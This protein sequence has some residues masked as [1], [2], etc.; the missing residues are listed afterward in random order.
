MKKTLILA[1]ATLFSL[2]GVALAQETG[3]VRDYWGAQN[4]ERATQPTIAAP[5]AVSAGTVRSFVVHSTT[6]Q[7]DAVSGLAGGGG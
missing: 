6:Q 1:A 3:A 7:S 4:F 2:G 5:A